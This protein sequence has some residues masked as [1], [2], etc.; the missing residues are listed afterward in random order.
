MKVNF[1]RNVFFGNKKYKV[2]V[3]EVDD[4]LKENWLFKSLI[5]K[6]VA[7]IMPHNAKLGPKSADKAVDPM[8]ENQKQLAAQAKLRANLKPKAK[9]EAEVKKG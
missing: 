8:S 4:G 2:G 5:E 3:H 6:E 1:K 9:P 7:V